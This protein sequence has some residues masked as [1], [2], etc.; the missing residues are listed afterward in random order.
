MA[1]KSFADKVRETAQTHQSSDILNRIQV[2]KRKSKEH[3]NQKFPNKE[4]ESLS[5]IKSLKTKQTSK[6][7]N[8][9]TNEQANKQTNERLPAQ[10]S[11]RTSEQTNKQTNE[12]TSEQ[13]NKRTNEQTTYFNPEL[14]P[15]NLKL[16]QFQVLH[17]IYFNRPFSVSGST[18]LSGFL[19]IKY[20]TVRNCLMSLVRK[21]YIEKPFRINDGVN[22]GS[23]CVV[24]ELKCIK[25]FGPTEIKQ[26]NKRTNEQTSEQTNK[27]TNEQTS[28][29]NKLVSKYLKLTN[30]IEH[31]NFWSSQGLSEKKCKEWI[32]EFYFNN[33]DVLLS[34]LMF[35]EYAEEN[36]SALQP[37]NKNKTP[38]HVFYGCL[39]KGGMTRPSG[40]EFPEEKTAR[41]KKEE[42]E[43]QKKLLAEQA[44]IREQEKAIADEM[45]FNEFLKNKESVDSLILEI[46]KRFITPKT[47]NSVKLYRKKGQIDSKLEKVLKLEFQKD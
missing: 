5:V 35:A 47:K 3:I 8:E 4:Q 11:K 34:Q 43:V 32:D 36:N 25:L 26:T 15:T 42:L 24:D 38:V 28:V 16:N 29:S 21:G 23:T 1:G 30:Y 9:Q 17:Y 19:N 45:A 2:I 20:G 41:I 37:K 39:K 13:T 46:E 14:C 27:R 7:T 31:S 22:N 33:P 40:F 6:R 44:V 10:T 18:G 12:Q